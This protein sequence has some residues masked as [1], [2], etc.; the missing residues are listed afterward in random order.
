MKPII[1]PLEGEINNHPTFDHLNRY[2]QD[3]NENKMNDASN[4]L[5]K[6]FFPTLDEPPFQKETKEVLD[7]L[8]ADLML[9]TKPYIILFNPSD[10][11]KYVFITIN[12][13]KSNITHDLINRNIQIGLHSG[14]MCFDAEYRQ[15]SSFDQGQPFL[16]LQLACYV[17]ESP[18][19]KIPVQHFN[20]VESFYNFLKQF[21]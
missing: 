12:A 16:V 3:L 5:D 9:G 4:I 6:S 2:S 7:Y 17:C 20:T 13:S 18:E 8:I 11:G 21:T 19:N 10:R 14:C 15:Q 1:E